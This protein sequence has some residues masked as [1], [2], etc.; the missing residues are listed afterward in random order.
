MK[1]FLG[2]EAERFLKGLPI[3]KSQ[4]CRDSSEVVKCAKRFRFP[5]VLKIISKH[6]VHK[7]DIGGIRIAKDYA[8]LRKN[9]VELMGLSRKKR[10][11][12]DGM[13]VQEYARGVEVIIG[14][15]RDRTFGHAIMFGI[16]GT[17]VELLRDVTFRICPISEQ[18]A[19]SMINDLKLVKLLQGFRGSKPANMKLLRSMLIKAS[20]IPL[21]HRKIEE[22]DINPLMID[23]KAAK[24]VDAR[25][26]IDF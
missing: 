23:G 20:R 14:I 15:K 7:T 1:I 3:A 10:I 26:V 19:E 6:V 21:K 24:I 5:L 11:K 9:Y 16:G 4:L 2:K 12:L 18:D 17:L 13:L 25:V 8:G 22:L